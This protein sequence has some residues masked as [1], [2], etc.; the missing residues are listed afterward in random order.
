[1]KN[2]ITEEHKHL[3]YKDEIG[4]V[5]LLTK[6]MEIYKKSD[7]TIGVYC[8]SKKVFLQLKKEG[9]V[10]KENDTDDKLYTFETDVANMH[11][12][13]ATGSHLRRVYCSGRWVKDK[14][15]R[16]GHKIIPFNP[17]L[18]EVE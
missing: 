10:S 7:S 6:H 2:I 18:S 13:F 5:F 4:D 11:L 3:L 9:I 14:E 8:W 15:K 1:M 17:S 16:L 12:L